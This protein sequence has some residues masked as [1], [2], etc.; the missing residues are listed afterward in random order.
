MSLPRAP[1]GAGTAGEARSGRAAP[2]G[3]RGARSRAPPQ[4]P[5]HRSC[6]KV[7]RA[8]P[9]AP[10]R[11]MQ[12]L[13][14]GSGTVR[15][16]PPC[17]DSPC[18]GSPYRHSCSISTESPAPGCSPGGKAR[19]RFAGELCLVVRA[20]RGSPPNAGWPGTKRLEVLWGASSR[21][22][23]RPAARSDRRQTLKTGLRTLSAPHPCFLLI[24]RQSPCSHKPA[25]FGSSEGHRTV[26]RGPG[27]PKSAGWCRCISA[28]CGF[29][30][31]LPNC[32]ATAQPS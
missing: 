8:K 31:V 1:P 28:A 30:C 26:T 14:G 9:A 24:P 10:A 22:V 13:G 5:P 25:A 29:L 7:Q 23:A 18:L 32:Q 6:T 19:Q 12:G 15:I 2:P 16:S 17:T 11:E 4:P 20:G 21:L 27:E 3:G